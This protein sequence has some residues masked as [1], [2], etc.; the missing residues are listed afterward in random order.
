MALTIQVD[1]VPIEADANGVL[2][3]GGTRVTLDTVVGWYREGARAEDIAR[4]Y[5]ALR[6]A[7]VYAAIAYYLRH[8]AEVDAYLDERERAASQARAENEA[9][10]DAAGVRERLAARAEELVVVAQASASGEWDGQ[11]RYLPLR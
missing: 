7:D 4:K 2:R 3:V 9:R 1:P 6:L 11:V 8:Q 5:D 10:F